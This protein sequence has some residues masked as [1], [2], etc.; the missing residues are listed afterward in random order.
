MSRE[1]KTTIPA[2][3]TTA[4]SRANETDHV[5]YADIA[6][7][8]QPDVVRN[9]VNNRSQPQDTV[10]YSTLKTENV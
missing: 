10:V 8:T 5:T 7:V 3:E 2:N 6:Q 4:S 1:D 9:G